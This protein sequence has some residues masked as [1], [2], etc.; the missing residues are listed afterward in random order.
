MDA[1]GKV[2]D[3]INCHSCGAVLD[4]AGQVGFTHIECKQCGA[5]SVVPL[6]FGDFLLLNVIGT[7]GTAT[8]YK[9]IDV[10]LNRYLALKVLRSDLAADPVMVANFSA[11]ARAAATVNHPNIAQVYS[12]GEIDHWHYMA[13]ELCEQGSLDHRIT[14]LGR[15]PEK[16]VLEIG[17]QIAS[18][19]RSAH[20]RGLL[21][22]DV[23]PGNVLFNEDGVPKLVDFGLAPGDRPE[24]EQIWGTPYYVAP[25]K[26]RGKPDD[27]RSDIYSLGA[28]LFH[29]LEGK[30]PASDAAAT[31]IADA[32]MA[33][34]RTV[35]VVE[36]MLALDPAERYGSY[37]EVI[38]DLSE[39][40]DA[41]KKPGASAPKA[42]A[43][44]K[45]LSALHLLGILI[46]CAAVIWFVWKYGIAVFQ[47][48]RRPSPSATIPAEPSPD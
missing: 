8:I 33:G 36:R 45:R 44:R 48:G 16:E 32:P 21:H 46:L 39:A 23:K 7:G 28:T 3:S 14:Q 35:Q 27:E 11:E 2:P 37:D 4:L 5:P 20:Q 30:P 22:R 24:G 29:A 17:V 12:F 26:L 13:L 10:L 19:L 42:T 47:S 9:S 31:G 40:L 25:E 43:G 38:E 15:I 6:E 18:A 41:L 34:E 1:P